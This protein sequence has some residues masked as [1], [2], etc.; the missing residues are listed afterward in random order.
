MREY[1]F[2]KTLG[3]TLGIMTILGAISFGALSLI[4][5]GLAK[6]LNTGHE[7]SS[8]EKQLAVWTFII[9]LSSGLITLSGAFKLQKKTWRLFYSIFCLMIGGGLL[10]LLFVSLGALG[11]KNEWF[12][13]IIGMIY[14]SLSILVKTGK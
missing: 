2:S 11:Y 5:M 8:N 3:V 14:L 6:A 10:T 12:I 1:I 9:A 7:Y 4:G 13:L